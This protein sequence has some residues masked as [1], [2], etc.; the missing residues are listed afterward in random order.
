MNILEPAAQMISFYCQDCN[1]KFVNEVVFKEHL[2]QVSYIYKA[3]IIV[4]IRHL[5]CKPV[6]MDNTLVYDWRFGHVTYIIMHVSRNS[7]A[8]ASEFLE[9][10]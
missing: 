8:F 2:A 5:F 3:F 9:N 4:Q 10:L 7:E 6:E 1:Q